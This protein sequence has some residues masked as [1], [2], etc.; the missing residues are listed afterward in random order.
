MMHGMNRQDI[1]NFHALVRRNP[2][3]AMQQMVY[4]LWESKIRELAISRFTW[5]GLPVE[6]SPRSLEYAIYQYGMAAFLPWTA[7]EDVVSK[8]VT[9]GATPSGILDPQFEPTKF[10]LMGNVQLTGTVTDKECVP[11]YGSL[12]RM[13]DSLTASVYARKLSR[14][15]RTIEINTDNARQPRILRMNEDNKLGLENFNN[16]LD[17]GTPVI[18]SGINL[19]DVVEVLDMGID[20][21]LFSEVSVAKQREF[22]MCLT[23]LGINNANTEKKER[24]VSDEARATE[25]VTNIIRQG[26][27]NARRRAARMI[28]ERYNLPVEVYYSNDPQ[29]VIHT[30]DLTQVGADDARENI[31]DD[32][33]NMIEEVTE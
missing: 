3:N 16:M 23:L 25:D 11:I 12:E 1:D 33:A 13:P 27:L 18:K 30:T 2:V 9:V 4:R 28:R 29:A 15:D 31:G 20:P 24:L 8:Y 6:V 22:Q 32:V 5:L 17:E 7:P 26:N 14:M 10:Q 21:K 19:G